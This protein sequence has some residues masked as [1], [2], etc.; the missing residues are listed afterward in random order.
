MSYADVAASTDIA[1]STLRILEADRRELYF[2]GEADDDR[3][4]AALDDL[5][6]LDDL[7]TEDTDLDDLRDRIAQLKHVV[8]L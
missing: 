1:E 2:T 3:V 6:P 4:D 5:R 8:D 7:R